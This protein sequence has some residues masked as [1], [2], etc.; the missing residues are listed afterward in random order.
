MNDIGVQGLVTRAQRGDPGAFGALYERLAP[1]LHN[2]LYHQT[3]G[4]VHLAEDLVED[5]FVRVLEKLGHYEDR[6]LP[7]VAWVYRIAHN[8]LVA[9]HRALPEQTTA[10]LGETFDP[11]KPAAVRVLNEALTP[12]SLVRALRRLTEE[13]RQAVVLR[14]LQGMSVAEAARTM[15]KTEDAVKKL[16]ARGLRTLRR[17]VGSAGLRD[18]VS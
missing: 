10:A 11:A 6:G 13:Q 8:R 15:G 4:D 17:S 12:A 18:L 5:V 14:F 7:F 16:Q 9:Y 1:K 3:G 2:Y